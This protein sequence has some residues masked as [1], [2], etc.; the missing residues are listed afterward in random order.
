MS[1]LMDDGR[2]RDES[3]GGFP[4]IKNCAAV[5]G[6]GHKTANICCPVHILSDQ[7]MESSSMEY[8]AIKAKS[9]PE[10]NSNSFCDKLMWANMSLRHIHILGF[11]CRSRVSSQVPFLRRKRRLNCIDH[12]T[13]GTGISPR[14]SR[15][16]VRFRYHR[17]GVCFNP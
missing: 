7:T 3:F 2:W 16:T 1:S 13:P 12:L 5:V 17:M 6:E 11:E 8:C 4:V 14:S 9:V 10:K 15:A